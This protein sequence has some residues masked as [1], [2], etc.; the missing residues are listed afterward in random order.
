MLSKSIV[1]PVVFVRANAIQPA[2][3]VDAGLPK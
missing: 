1:E 2:T 3:A